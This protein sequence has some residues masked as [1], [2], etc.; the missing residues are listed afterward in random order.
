MDHPEDFNF[1]TTS[2]AEVFEILSLQVGGTYFRTIKVQVKAL[3]EDYSY[4]PLIDGY[5]RIK[6]GILCNEVKRQGVVIDSQYQPV[7]ELRKGDT[8]T[9]YL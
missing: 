7:L 4:Y 1:I 9:L 2:F 8:L 5:L 3:A 6:D